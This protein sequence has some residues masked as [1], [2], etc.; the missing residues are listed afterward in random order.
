MVFIGIDVGGSSI[1]GAPVDVESGV[2]A[3]PLSAV[4]TPSPATPTAVAGA[5]ARPHR[6]TA[7]FPAHRHRGPERGQAR[8]DVD[9]GQ[10]RFQLDRC[11]HGAV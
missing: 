2:L 3:A 9:R 1:K 5:I 6:A 11:E 7:A 8:R 10:Y 4:P